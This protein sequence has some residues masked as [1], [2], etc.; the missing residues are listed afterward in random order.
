EPSPA[1]NPQAHRA[2]QERSPDSGPAGHRLE[3]AH[4]VAGAG[5]PNGSHRGGA[6]RFQ[7]FWWLMAAHRDLAEHR[8]GQ[9]TLGPWIGVF[10]EGLGKFPV[11]TSYPRACSS[12]PT[13]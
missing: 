5:A 13:A 8:I 6:T 9:E 4:I 12:P 3:H 2:D 7:P 1:P 10:C 11:R